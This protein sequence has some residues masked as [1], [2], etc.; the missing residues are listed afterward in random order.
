MKAVIDQLEEISPTRFKEISAA[1]RNETSVSEKK[2]HKLLDLAIEALVKSGIPQGDFHKSGGINKVLWDLRYVEIKDPTA[3]LK[4]CSSDPN[5]FVVK[6]AP[7]SSKAAAVSVQPFVQDV[8][9]QL[10][11]MRPGTVEGKRFV[12][13]KNLSK[14]IALLGTLTALSNEIEE[15]QTSNNI[16]TFH[17]MHEKISAIVRNNSAPF[18]YERLGS[19]YNHI[20]MDEF[21]DTSVT[22]WHNLVVLYDHAL[23]NNHKTLVV[24]DGKQA[25][26][27]F[28]NGDYKQLM[29]LPNLQ[30]GDNGPAIS[31]AEKSFIREA[32]ANT[33]EGN[34]RT[35][36]KIVEWNNQLFN[37]MKSFVSDELK[38]VY[39]D[40]AQTLKRNLT[41]EFFRNGS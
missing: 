1:L 14:R 29:D 33:L 41:V 34:Y 37:A 10:L 5:A 23:A 21:Q 32:S 20:F 12:L 11:K 31:D 18:I 2:L 28:R 13:A 9:N 36:R 40:L 25:I 16:R 22:Q 15:V 6:T 30:T 39:D 35:G 27:R 8:Y 4:S 3:R 19:R 17:A 38:N 26:Y 24:G 7:Q